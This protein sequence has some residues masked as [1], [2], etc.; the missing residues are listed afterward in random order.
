MSDINGCTESI[1]FYSE[2]HLRFQFF[3][4]ETEKLNVTVFC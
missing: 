3:P 1:K 4:F 2:L